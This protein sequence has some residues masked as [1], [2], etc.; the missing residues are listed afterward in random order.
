MKKTGYDIVQEVIEDALLAFPVS[1][2]LISFYKQYQ[3][4]GFLTKKQLQG[5][6]SKAASSN[7]INP[8]KLAT[9]EAL[10]KKMPTRVKSELPELLPEIEPN[11]EVKVMLDKVLIKFPMHKRALFFLS[12]HNNKENLTASELNDLK[13]FLKIAE[14]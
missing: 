7:K 3:Q 13:Q 10:I 2:L 4:R 12:K 1:P 8:G 14:R 11:P 5:L 6:H 9:L